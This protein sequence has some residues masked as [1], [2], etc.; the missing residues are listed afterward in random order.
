MN[1]EILKMMSRAIDTNY[2]VVI[3]PESIEGK[4]INEMVMSGI[5]PSEI[6]DII[7]SNTFNGITAKLKFNMWKK[8]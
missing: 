8:L 6:S 3:W 2:N 7:S 4:D 1:K 5:S